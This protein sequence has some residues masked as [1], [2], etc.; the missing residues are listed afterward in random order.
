MPR[1]SPAE[2]RKR[3]ADLYR[4]HDE[5]QSEVLSAF[6]DSV[7]SITLKAVAAL[8]RQL[9]RDLT[10]DRKGNVEHTPSNMR[11]LARIDKQY[12]ELLDKYGYNRTIHAFLAEFPGQLPVL[13][14]ILTTI[15]QTL[16]KPF[17]YPDTLLTAA[18]Q[19]ALRTQQNITGESL[20]DLAITLGKAAKRKALLSVGGLDRETLTDTISQQLGKMRGESANLAATALAVWYRTANAKVFDKIQ[21]AQTEELKYTIDGPRDRLNRPICAQMCAKRDAGVTWTKEELQAIRNPFGSYWDVGGGINCRHAP[22]LS[23]PDETG[24]DVVAS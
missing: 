18:D 20:M 1:L 11:T 22:R 3:L 19:R 4:T 13:R 10:F 7:E 8:V 24:I 17:R 14:D 2:A 12:R 9:S 21:R 15:G 5:W 23:L 16:E 6:E